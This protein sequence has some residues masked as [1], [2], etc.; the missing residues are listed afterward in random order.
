MDEM[1]SGN[2][3]NGT[4]K[5][6]FLMLDIRSNGGNNRRQKIESRVKL[7]KTIMLHSDCLTSPKTI[8]ITLKINNWTQN[9]HI[10]RGRDRDRDR[11]R[12]RSSNRKKNKNRNR[13]ST[14]WWRYE[15]TI[16]Q[17]TREQRWRCKS[18]AEIIIQKKKNGQ[19]RW[20]YDN[21]RDTHIH[22]NDN[23]R[24]HLASEKR[25]KKKQWNYAHVS[26]KPCHHNC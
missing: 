12:D 5:K 8:M 24:R 18:V 14:Q 4:I 17:Q 16:T 25:E 6:H 19:N 10:D 15:I 11:D 9:T 1:K 2:D 20:K 13:V 22:N 21:E 23:N 3:E 26:G 7:R